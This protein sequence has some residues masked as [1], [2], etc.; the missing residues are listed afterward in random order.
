MTKTDLQ[1]ADIVKN[2]E[3]ELP[4]PPEPPPRLSVRS[5]EEILAME[6]DDSDVIWGDRLLASEQY[7]TV[8]AQGGTGK[9]RLLLQSAF[10][11][12]AGL[13]FLGIDTH[14]SHLRWL[15]IQGENSSRR[16]KQDLWNLRRWAEEKRC[17]ASWLKFTQQVSIHTLEND[18]DFNLSLD[19]AE[20][21]DLISA[22]IQ[23]KQPDIVAFD[24]LNNFGV[25][26]LNKD[27][28]MRY[29]C[30]AI[31]RIVKHGNPR[32]ATIVAHHSAT[33]KAGT[34]KVVGHDR[35]SFGRNSKV[36]FN[37]T[38]AQINI[39]PANPDDNNLLIVSCGKCSNGKLFPPFA[40][41]LNEET[42]IYDME[43][44]FDINGWQESLEKG[45]KVKQ[46]TLPE[47]AALCQG[48]RVEK[49]WLKERIM[50]AIDC[51]KSKA[52]NLINAAIK[53]RYLHQSKIDD[54]IEQP[55]ERKR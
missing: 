39:A 49:E 41:R 55:A 43:E 19:T 24:P 1:E 53:S 14:G 4:D 36:L 48:Q 45:G 42:M 50:E 30:N 25:G 11:T 13:P 2:G 35:T 47:V 12:V 18:T 6:F 3:V 20:N 23:E 8:V 40:I 5:P 32:R 38:R 7:L 44:G 37:W 33:G 28:D 52:Y 34:A 51:Q 9:S 22:L 46:I 26:D 27:E 31:S 17:K 21:I 10:C 15:I 29:T 16:L 54:L